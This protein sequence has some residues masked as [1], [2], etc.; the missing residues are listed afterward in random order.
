VLDGCELQPV[1]M[2][3]RSRG[4]LRH[5]AE[6]GIA[7]LG[8]RKRRK[9]PWANSLVT[10]HLRHVRLVHRARANVLRVDA[11]CRSELMLQPKTPLQEI[12]RVKRSAGDRRD[13]HGRKTCG[14]IGLWGL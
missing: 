1:V 10:V 4:E 11:C 13:G 5:R 6:S 8:I 14:G 9:A 3:A 7:R 2:A 12:G